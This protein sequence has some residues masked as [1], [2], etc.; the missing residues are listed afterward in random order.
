MKDDPTPNDAE[1]PLPRRLRAG[2]MT[3]LLSGM[4]GFW[5]GA[6]DGARRRGDLSGLLYMVA[7]ALWFSLM[8]ALAKY[9]LPETPTQAIVLTRGIA[10]TVVFVVLAKRRSVPL[11]GK[12]PAQ[13]FLRGFLGYLAVSAYFYSV[14]HLPVGDAVLIQYSHPIFVAAIAP[15][16]LGERTSRGHWPLVLV[17]LLG[18]ALVV[19]PSGDIRGDAVVGIFGSICSG[20]AYMTVRHLSKTEHP[21]TILVWFP[22]VTIPGALIGTWRALAAGLPALPRNGR[23][24]LG[25]VA[26][27]V[28]ALLGQ[29]TLTQGL[30]R[31]GAARGTAV[32]MTGPIFGLFFGWLLFDTLPGLWSLAGT[33]LVIVSLITLASQKPR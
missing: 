7:S 21:L 28:A 16:L 32:T 27:I 22:A 13:L 4:G 9:L 24:A 33:A 12:S 3:L 25:H 29:W 15:W 6:K 23:E 11:L 8:A 1:A 30:A 20:L 10:M 2:T 19:G 5:E 31:A 14:Q 18:L 26:V 17:A